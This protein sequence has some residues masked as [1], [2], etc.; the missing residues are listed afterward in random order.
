[1]K[2]YNILEEKVWEKSV[3]QFT[4]ANFLQS[5]YWGNFQEQLGNKV[6]RISNDNSIAQYY[7]V[8]SRFANFLYCP[9]GPLSTSSKTFKIVCF[10]GVSQ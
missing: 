2:I 3:S 6:I 10:S 9:R 5:W 7:F 4:S 1:M 8:K